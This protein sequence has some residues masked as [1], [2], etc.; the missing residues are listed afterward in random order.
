[1]AAPGTPNLLARIPR[2]TSGELRIVLDEFHGS[3]TIQLQAL[4]LEGGRLELRGR[5]S[6]WISEIPAVLEALESAWDQ[7]RRGRR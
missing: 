6:L 1:M 5:F 4:K 7:A 2:G 3:P